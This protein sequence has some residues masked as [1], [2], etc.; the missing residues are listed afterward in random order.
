MERV[1]NLEFLKEVGYTSDEIAIL[2]SRIDTELKDKLN[3]F[4][5]LVIDN[6]KYLKDLGVKNYKEIF[7][8]FGSLFLKNNSNFTGIFS[9]YEISDLIDKL[10]KNPDIVEYL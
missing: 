2:E 7:N 9:K 8:K 3:M 1:F 6:I 10:E 5:V 4:P